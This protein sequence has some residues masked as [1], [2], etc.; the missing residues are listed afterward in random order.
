ML[1]VGYRV[2]VSNVLY[3]SLIAKWLRLRTQRGG[4][5]FSKSISYVYGCCTL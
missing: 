5:N 3:F 4:M 2:V 1:G